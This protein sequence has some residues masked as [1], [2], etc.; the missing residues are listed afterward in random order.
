MIT[1]ARP[2]LPRLAVFLLA[3]VLAGCA[4]GPD[5]RDPWEPWNRRVDSFNEHVDTVVL[6]PVAIAYREIVPPLARTG[7]SNFYGNL[8][9]AWSAVNS[10]LQLKV[11]Q[12]ADN[13]LRFSFNTVFGLG[14][15]LDI[16]TEMGIDRHR[17]DFG[18]TLGFWGVGHGPYMVLPILGPSTV[19]DTLALPVDRRGDPLR[20]VGPA[21]LETGLYALRVVDFRSNVLRASSVLD[22]VALDKYRF[23][24]DAYL[25]RRRAQAPGGPFGDNPA[26]GED[27]KDGSIPRED[28]DTRLPSP[29]SSSPGGGPA[30]IP[31][32]PLR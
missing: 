26:N 29:P 20:L 12:A 11:Q 21:E 15:V 18:Q 2:L 28:D 1:R 13:M 17:E 3:G 6:K 14:G 19:R 23:T 5:P 16:A 30:N 25:Q 27:A 8:S 4:S 31:M 32:M 22:Q 7:V 9:D 10:L 24:R